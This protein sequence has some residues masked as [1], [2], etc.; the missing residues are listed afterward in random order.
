M[1]EENNRLLL[2]VDELFKLKREYEKKIQILQEELENKITDDSELL[3][4]YNSESAS[5]NKRLSEKNF[6]ISKLKDE[7]DKLILN[8]EVIFIKDIFVAYPN[9]TNLELN[10]ELYLSR[11]VLKNIGILFECEKMKNE[12]SQIELSVIF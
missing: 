4:Y 7:I 8:H 9:K 2:R 3:N 11:D 5:L 12:K 10:S 1:K 6:S